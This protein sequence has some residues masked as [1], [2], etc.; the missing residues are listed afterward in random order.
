MCMLW[1]NP[2]GQT[3]HKHHIIQLILKTLCRF[4]GLGQYGACRS[5]VDPLITILPPLS[6]EKRKWV[7]GGITETAGGWQ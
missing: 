3:R 1:G 4:L 2:K 7:Q 6:L 5:D